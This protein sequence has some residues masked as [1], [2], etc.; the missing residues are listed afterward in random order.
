M[1]TV[2]LPRAARK[3]DV[4]PIFWL[5]VLLAC[6]IAPAIDQSQDRVYRL[7]ITVPPALISLYL[8]L[9]IWQRDARKTALLPI[10]ASL[11]YVEVLVVSALTDFT[12]GV[13]TFFTPLA[14][15]IVGISPPDALGGV[16]MIRRVLA[17]LLI[18]SFLVDAEGI[19]TLVQPQAWLRGD[20]RASGIWQSPHVFAFAGALLLLL[21]FA[22]PTAGSR[23]KILYALLGSAAVLSASSRGVT[24]SLVMAILVSSVYRWNVAGLV[25][26]FLIVVLLGGALLYFATAIKSVDLHAATL[27]GRTMYWPRYLPYLYERPWFGWG[28]GLDQ[29]VIAERVVPRFFNTPHNGYLAMLLYGGVLGLL[30][31]VMVLVRLVN[32]LLMHQRQYSLIALAVFL[33]LSLLTETRLDFSVAGLGSLCVVVLCVTAA[34]HVKKGGRPEYGRN[35]L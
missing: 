34:E 10:F 12:P 27:T 11:I 6:A 18:T 35:S 32:A 2:S 30:I 25:K 20:E 1:S 33:P 8:L 21:T 31:L 5:G 29:Q 9:R 3:R 17:V 23:V 15:V 4:S 26:I 13:A 22:K 24:V 19:A 7:F 28:L 16:T 14:L